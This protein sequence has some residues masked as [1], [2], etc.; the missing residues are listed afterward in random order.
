MHGRTAL[1]EAAWGGNA[2]VVE[3][4]I[5]KGADVNA[6]DSSGYTAIMRASEEG[7]IPVVKNS[8]K[9]WRR[10]KCTGKSTWNYII[11]VS[12]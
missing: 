11:N 2:A 10:C 6:A 12:R 9:K 3:L 4:L 7:F 1:I 5:K 8:Y